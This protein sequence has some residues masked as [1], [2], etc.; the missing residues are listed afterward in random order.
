MVM[1]VSRMFWAISPAAAPVVS[2]GSITS[3]LSHWPQVTV[4]PFVGFSDADAVGAV[5][6]G[7]H[8][9]IATLAAARAERRRNSR[10]YICSFIVRLPHPWS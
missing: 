2:A 4:P 8:A 10:R 6:A 5:A 7:A 3:I 9:K 1:S